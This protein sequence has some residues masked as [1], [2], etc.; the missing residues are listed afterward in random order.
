MD[1]ISCPSC[2]K[3]NSEDNKFCDFCLSALHPGGSGEDVFGAP[4]PPVS[5][6]NREGLG[7]HESDAEAPDW[8]SELQG[9]KE[10]E[11]EEPPGTDS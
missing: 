6:G 8:L 5:G 4:I 1:Q 3:P 2:G 9:S 10:V 11:P 7:G